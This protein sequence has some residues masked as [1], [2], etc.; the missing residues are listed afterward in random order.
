MTQTK[1]VPSNVRFFPS[2]FSRKPPEPEGDLELRTTYDVYHLLY[3]LSP[4]AR[5]G[6]MDHVQRIFK[7]EERR[8]AAEY[9]FED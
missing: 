7:R 2:V 3:P 4:E 1:R 8:N 6:V 5:D 9:K